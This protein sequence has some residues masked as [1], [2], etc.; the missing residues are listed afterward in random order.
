MRLRSRRW[1]VT[2]SRLAKRPVAEYAELAL[3]GRGCRGRTRWWVRT[4]GLLCVMGLVRLSRWWPVVAGVVLTGVGIVLRGGSGGVVLLPGLL[5]L[6]S[7]PLIPP[8]PKA[9]RVRR[10][11]LEREMAA[12]STPAQRRDLETTLNRYPD[13]VTHELRDILTRQATACRH[14]LP[15]GGPS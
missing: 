3:A 7:A 15:G 10:A 14:G 2:E 5:L 12:Y 9:E 4:G 8:S 13:G 11:V 1:S 6:L